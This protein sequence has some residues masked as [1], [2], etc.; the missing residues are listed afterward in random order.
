MLKIT[1]SGRQLLCAA[2]TAGWV[3][4]FA[5]AAQATIIISG[6]T[7]FATAE[8][9][10]LNANLLDSKVVNL[11]APTFTGKL[12]SEVYSGDEANDLGGLTFVYW[13]ENSGPNSLARLTVSSF[14]GF[15]TDMGYVPTDEDPDAVLPT[16]VDRS[17]GADPLD[18]TGGDVVGFSFIGAPLGSGKIVPGKHSNLLIVRTNAEAYTVTTA[19]VIN[20]STAN[21]A[22][23]APTAVIPEPSTLALASLGFVGLVGMTIRRRRRA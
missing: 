18:E 14:T 13:V 7:E 4:T 19:A 22:S 17:L 3:L 1:K 23:F 6:Q 9:P 5:N 16:L 11:V 15:E 20:G 12:Y 2:L 10:P 21:P 8:V